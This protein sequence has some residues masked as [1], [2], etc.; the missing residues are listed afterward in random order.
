M[1]LQSSEDEIYVE[2]LLFILFVCSHWI[3]IVG[4]EQQ[5]PVKNGKRLLQ[6]WHAHANYYPL[7]HIVTKLMPMHAHIIV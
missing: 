3:N 2:L 5:A 6:C 7:S 1:K 4:Y